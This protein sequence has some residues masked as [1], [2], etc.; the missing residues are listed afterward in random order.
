LRD[1]RQLP[2][3]AARLA[4]SGERAREPRRALDARARDDLG[5]EAPG[6]V[7]ADTAPEL[8]AELW[9]RA[10]EIGELA[11]AARIEPFG[12]LTHDDVIDAVGPRERRRRTRIVL[13][14]PH[15]RVRALLPP[16]PADDGGRRGT[17]RGAEED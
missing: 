12:E 5:G 2:R 13:H 6:A 17:A 15:A 9:Q 1:A 14:G 11:L 4:A 16:E 3:R 10:R 7:V 8:V